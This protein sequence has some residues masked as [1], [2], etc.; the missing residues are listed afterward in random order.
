MAL[1]YLGGG[2]QNVENVLE[3]RFCLCRRSGLEDPSFFLGK[4]GV[5]RRE[6]GRRNGQIASHEKFLL[7]WLPEPPKFHLALRL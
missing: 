5:F 4:L 3:G 6:L 7:K 1:L 2:G